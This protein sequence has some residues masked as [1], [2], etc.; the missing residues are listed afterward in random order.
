MARITLWFL[1]T[2]AAVNLVHATPVPMNN[3]NTAGVDPPLDA[4]PS[5][6]QQVDT[7]PVASAADSTYPSQS[8]STNQ[9]SHQPAQ[10]ERAVNI[11]KFLNGLRTRLGLPSME[12]LYPQ[13]DQLNEKEP[14]AQ[15]G[16]RT[17]L[18]CA[19]IE[20]R[21]TFTT[22]LSYYLSRDG[23]K[24]SSPQEYVDT[25]P[26][27]FQKFTLAGSDIPTDSLQKIKANIQYKYVLAR[28]TSHSLANLAL[29]S[30]VTFILKVIV[31]LFEAL[32]SPQLLENFRAIAEQMWP[33]LQDDQGVNSND[34]APTAADPA[35]SDN[36]HAIAK[37]LLSKLQGNQGAS[38]NSHVPTAMDPSRSYPFYV[39]MYRIWLEIIGGND[40]NQ[41]R[42]YLSHMLAF[43]VIPHII[44]QM[45]EHGQHA[46]ALELAGKAARTAGVKWVAE[47]FDSNAPNYFEFIVQYAAI[48]YTPN[49]FDLIY[50]AYLGNEGKEKIDVQFLYDCKESKQ[51]HSWPI[52]E[53][54]FKV[55]HPREYEK[56]SSKNSS[57]C[58]A[59]LAKYMYGFWN[60]VGAEYE[61]IYFPGEDTKVFENT[62]E[63]HQG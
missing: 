48:P 47:Q 28:S 41:L 54:A 9:K 15:V 22:V 30:D 43:R 63:E 35:Q 23:V 50:Y 4:L 21:A 46:K 45:I 53:D 10:S 39:F 55:Q 40:V 49:N 16:L 38:S 42:Y 58:K 56:W 12:K 31:A 18:D 14:H 7:P 26:N 6:V 8:G 51:G 20:F 1:A 11:A 62:S 5:S 59:R 32:E 33:E 2:M 25:Y 19:Q 44:G 27:L 34:L 13:V 36:F 29:N 57:L 17:L 3:G 52:V 60:S 61:I 24:N 37:Q